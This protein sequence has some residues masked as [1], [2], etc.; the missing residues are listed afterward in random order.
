M[1]CSCTQ[2]VSQTGTPDINQTV[3]FNDVCDEELDELEGNTTITQNVGG[4]TQT[5]EQSCDCN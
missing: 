1:D 5:I 2:L 4:I 3:E